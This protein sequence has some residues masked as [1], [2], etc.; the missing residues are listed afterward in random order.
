[1]PG[2]SGMTRMSIRRV[3]G[4]APLPPRSRLPRPLTFLFRESAPNCRPRAP[5]AP[6]LP[7]F[8]NRPRAPNPPLLPKLPNCPR[9]PIAP[10]F[11]PLARAGLRPPS[12]P[13]FRPLPSAAVGLR[14]P[15]PNARSPVPLPCGPS[16]APIP[17]R[18]KFPC[19]RGCRRLAVGWG[20]RGAGWQTNVAP[21][22]DAGRR[23]W[24]AVCRAWF[25]RSRQLET[26]APM[27]SSPT[28]SSPAAFHHRACMAFSLKSHDRG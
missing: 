3:P 14:A 12:A 6:L 28:M 4:G 1:M 9:A 26:T 18:T 21:R 22:V 24:A 11:L 13:T 27:P 8:A 2:G 15:G 25:R 17:G 5:N 20:V 16:A 7:K 19:R 10:G 23:A